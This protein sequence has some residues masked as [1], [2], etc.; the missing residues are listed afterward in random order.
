MAGQQSVSLKYNPQPRSTKKK[1]VFMVFGQP[2]KTT[3]KSHGPTRCSNN[4]DCCSDKGGVLAKGWG[5]EASIQQHT[6]SRGTVFSKTTVLCSFESQ[7]VAEGE[8]VY[9]CVCVASH[10]T[11]IIPMQPPPMSTFSFG[12]CPVVQY[13]RMPWRSLCVPP[14]PF[15]APHG[16][17]LSAGPTPLGS[18]LSPLRMACQ[19]KGHGRN[20][21]AYPG[22][23]GVQTLEH[24][25]TAETRVQVGLRAIGRLIG[26]SA[27]RSGL[28]TASVR[29]NTRGGSTASG[30]FRDLRVC[31]LRVGQGVCIA[32]VFSH[33]GPGVTVPSSGIRRAKLD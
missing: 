3:A 19:T 10:C 32:C 2:Q 14:P 9:G 24:T 30:R 26:R 4:T 23:R 16:P 6:L 21:H 11:T 22:G 27:S 33:S 8:G 5:V 13:R 7:L 28:N 15:N 29:V 31:L 25:D 1:S 20:S 18:A 17:P 12:R